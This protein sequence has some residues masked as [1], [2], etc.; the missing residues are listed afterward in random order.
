MRVIDAKPCRD[1]S[2]DKVIDSD[3]PSRHSMEPLGCDMLSK[4]T[5]RKWLSQMKRYSKKFLL[6]RLYMPPLLLTIAYFAGDVVAEPFQYASRA[7]R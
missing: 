4:R 2:V 3:K 7:N 5:Y 6:L 1:L